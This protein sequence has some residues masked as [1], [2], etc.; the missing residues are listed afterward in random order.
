MS[1]DDLH[2]FFEKLETDEILRQ[3]VI[4]LD[5]LADEERAR[6]VHDIAAREGY[7]IT[8]EDWQH[9]SVSPAVESLS[10]EALR[11]VVA[12]DGCMPWAWLGGSLG[13]A[14]GSGCGQSVGAYGAGCEQSVGKAA[15][16]GCG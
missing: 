3:E 16:S 9:E 14:G 6:A 12:G 13:A 10:D 4:A 1:V 2:A 15:G 11:G 7:T 8:A 5:A